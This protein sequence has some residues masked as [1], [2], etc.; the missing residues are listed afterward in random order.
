MGINGINI[1]FLGYNRFKPEGK[2]DYFNHFQPN[3]KLFT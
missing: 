2:L 3:K 1:V